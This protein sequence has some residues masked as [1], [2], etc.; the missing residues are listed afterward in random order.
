MTLPALQKETPEIKKPKSLS[1]RITWLRDYY[2]KGT[3]RAWNNEYTAWST[4]TPWD[5]QFNE[6]T[7]YIVPETYMLMQTMVSSYRQAA[8][9]V[10]LDQNFWSWSLPERRAWFVKETMVNYVPQEI[11]P[12]DLIAGGRF[13]VQT[14]L[15]LNQQ[16]QKQYDKLT[17]GKNGAR[18][19]MKRF[20]DHGYGNSGATSGHLIP[21]HEKALQVGWKGIHTDLTDK[22][23]QLSQSEKNSSK[24]AQLRAMITAST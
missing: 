3:E 19:K 18:D 4:G 9:P 10:T 2:F 12:G 13:N 7:F 20:H 21:G 6:M 23:N 14:S 1:S 16:E 8:R 24:G 17:A 15:C 5:I 22:Y 11:L